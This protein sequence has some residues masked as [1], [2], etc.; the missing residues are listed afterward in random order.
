MNRPMIKID[1]MALWR[2]SSNR[3]C[4]GVFK[5]SGGIGNLAS[6]LDKG[7]DANFLRVKRVIGRRRRDE[8]TNTR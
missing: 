4:R 6:R 7:C 5:G 2:Y 8:V 3:D 1:G